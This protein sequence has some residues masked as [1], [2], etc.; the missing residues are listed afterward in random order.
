MKCFLQNTLDAFNDNEEIVDQ[1]IFINNRE[2]NEEE[3]EEDTQIK[4]M[5]KMIYI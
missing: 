3:N 1:D 5:N 2:L 4:T